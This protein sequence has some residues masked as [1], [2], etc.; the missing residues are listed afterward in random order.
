[1]GTE[2]KNKEIFNC[3]RIWKTQEKIKFPFIQ[4]P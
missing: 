2:K 4:E 1:M 3:K